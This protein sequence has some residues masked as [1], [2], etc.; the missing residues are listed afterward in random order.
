MKFYIFLF[1][2]VSTSI[3]AQ[4][5]MEFTDEVATKLA[6]KPLKCIN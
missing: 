2:L 4:N 3:C 1:A 6:E 5:K